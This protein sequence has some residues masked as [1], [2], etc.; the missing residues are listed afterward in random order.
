MFKYS[1]QGLIYCRVLGGQG[2]FLNVMFH[3]FPSV[4]DTFDFISS[5]ETLFSIKVHL[6]S[7]FTVLLFLYNSNKSIF[8]FFRESHEPVWM[9]TWRSSMA[10]PF[11]REGTE[12]EGSDLFRNTQQS[13][14]EAELGAGSKLPKSQKWGNPYVSPD[15]K[16]KGRLDFHSFWLKVFWKEAALGY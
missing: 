4:S 16:E 3:I 10:T 11:G 1:R 8:L 13:I 9:N 7:L 12:A 5:R 14:P 2:T 15:L 6:L